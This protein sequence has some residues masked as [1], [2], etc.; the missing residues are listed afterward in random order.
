L[1]VK[2]VDSN[3]DKNSEIKGINNL[4]SCY[5]TEKKIVRDPYKGDVA[6]ERKLNKFL[7]ILFVAC[8]V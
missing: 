5:G 1:R 2:E 6:K 8:F 4:R 7:V 3:A